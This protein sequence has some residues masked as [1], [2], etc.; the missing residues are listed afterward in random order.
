MAGRRRDVESLFTAHFT[1]APPVIDPMGQALTGI[2]QKGFII[3]VH[4]S[5]PQDRVIQERASE[6]LEDVLAALPSP[7]PAGLVT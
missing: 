3:A 5:W 7:L 4:I 6:R 1:M 2:F